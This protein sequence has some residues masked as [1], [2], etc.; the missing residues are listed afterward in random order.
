MRNHPFV[1]VPSNCSIEPHLFIQFVLKF[2][3]QK[4]LFFVREFEVFD[5]SKLKVWRVRHW[6]R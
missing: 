3:V 2:P 4:T 6:E 5:K 1:Q